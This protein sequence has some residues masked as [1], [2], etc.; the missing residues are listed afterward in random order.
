MVVEQ[1]RGAQSAELRVQSAECQLDQSS[2]LMLTSYAVAVA[3]CSFLPLCH[4]S[5]LRCDNSPGVGQYETDLGLER[6]ARRIQRT[7]ENPKRT[8][9]KLPLCLVAS[10]WL[11][12]WTFPLGHPTLQRPESGY[13]PT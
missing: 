9:D 2:P 3:G 12:Q 4:I 11:P 1:A 10:A 13:I 8:A 6:I 5:T 7:V